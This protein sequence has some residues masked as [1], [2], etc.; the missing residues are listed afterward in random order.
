LRIWLNV[1]T[2]MKPIIEV[3]NIS[4]KYQI[5]AQQQRYLSL[6]DSLGSFFSFNKNKDKEEFWALKDIDFKVEAG[7]CIGIIG[8]NGAGKST[9]LKI[10]SRITP[11]TK[12]QVILRGRLASLLEVGT[13]FH[14]ELSGREN[15]Y[16]NGSIMGLKKAEI[17]K[18]FDE[19][20]D[21]SG[22]EQFIDTPLKNYSSG[23]QM[24]LAFAVSVYLESE[25][26]IVDEVL[27]VGDAEFQKKCLRKME[28]LHLEGK[29]ILLVSH[30]NNILNKLC[31]KGAL[32]NKNKLEKYA[33]IDEIVELYTDKT[34]IIK[35][36]TG[37]IIWSLEN[38]PGKSELKLLALRLTDLEGTIKSTFRSDENIKIT[39]HYLLL[40]KVSNMRIN[41][42]IRTKD[43]DVLFA[44]STHDTEQ[45]E[46]DT[47]YYSCSTVL[48][49]NIFNE[50]RFKVHI[51]GGIPNIRE[52][53]APTQPLE[54]FIDKVTNSGTIINRLLPG[55]FAPILEWHIIKKS[56]E[57]YS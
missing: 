50:D 3:Q 17:D 31:S 1:T 8:S 51:Q 18:K 19:I 44:S 56:D 57:Y 48:P 10:L 12:G 40:D 33:P 28:N 21:F 46:K 42:Q 39:I 35:P 36:K 55:F 29:T 43:D 15:V 2:Y 27:A 49:K 4:K 11:P 47:G 20:V 26:L 14:P 34:E 22:V 7:E 5:N 13:G 41:L 25:I 37:E 23:M 9:L 53:L 30:N 38:A 54:F 6:R 32:L 45:Y 52:L 24:R 16:F